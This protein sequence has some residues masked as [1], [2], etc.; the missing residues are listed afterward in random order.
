MPESAATRIS[1][2]EKAALLLM[3]LGTETAAPVLQQLSPEEVQRLCDGI[4]RSKDAD[5]KLRSQVL[6]EVAVSEAARSGGGLDFA[7]ELLEQSLGGSKAR[8]M[9]AEIARATVAQ[10]FEWVTEQDTSRLVPCL[11]NEREQVITLVLAHL[12][13]DLAAAVLA[14]LPHDQQGKIAYRLTAMQP[15]D[16]EV[17]RIVEDMVKARMSSRDA[18]DRRSV[19]GLQSLV[20]ILNSADRATENKI[21]DFL[22]G[23]EAGIA[24]SVREMMFVFEDVITL[25]DR[26][27]QRVT[28]ELEMDDLSLSLKGASEE[29]KE[30]FFRNMSERAADAL[31]EELE[32][33]GPAKRKDVE[34]AQRRVVS[35]VRRLEKSGDISLHPEQ[36]DIIA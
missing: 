27:L 23:S 18:G 12:P 34:A 14:Q 28:R 25:D 24:R 9:L 16:S 7:R 30:E 10:P 26:S 36:D 20:S 35:V 6:R 19:G 29:T 3:A 2:T 13:S 21:L 5:P 33:M 15:V 8:D 17:V 31:K 22:H 1:G 4:A 11:R 32:T